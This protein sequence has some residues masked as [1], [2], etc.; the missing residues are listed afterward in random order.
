[1]ASAHY[2]HSILY[3]GENP[4]EAVF[5]PKRK[6]APKIL[7]HRAGAEPAFLQK[8]AAEERQRQE[9]RDAAAAAAALKGRREQR[10]VGRIVPYSLKYRTIL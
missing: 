3:K 5:Q 10:I 4:A 7:R 1:M 9:E 2:Q 8:E 6:N